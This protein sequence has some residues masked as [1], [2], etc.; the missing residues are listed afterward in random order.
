MDKI[1]FNSLF[2]NDIKNDKNSEFYTVNRE[3][4]ILGDTELIL[5]FD[6][7]QII[8][9]VTLFER[10]F[11]NTQ[12]VIISGRPC[13]TSLCNP[14]NKYCDSSGVPELVT[15]NN[16]NTVS[17][18]IS[19]NIDNNSRMLK[20]QHKKNCPSKLQQFNNNRFI[21][22]TK[23]CA[24]PGNPNFSQSSKRISNVNW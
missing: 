3:D 7:Q 16:V 5:N 2:D 18:K 13:N 22:N 12:N 11:F 6:K 24:N 15:K 20:D 9:N 1:K 8:D 10:N 14:L 17:D 21:N 23:F 19:E 4:E